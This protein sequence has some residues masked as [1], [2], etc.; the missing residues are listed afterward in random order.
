MENQDII[1]ENINFAYNFREKMITKLDKK[2]L[3][4]QGTYICDWYLKLQFED[5]DDQVWDVYLAFDLKL[6]K[7]EDIE[8]IY[9][10]IKE[11]VL[12]INVYP[13]RGFRKC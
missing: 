2:I 10:K 4:L 6:W 11:L 12:L 3:K 5:F 7:I 9:N 1:Q 8:E 13:G